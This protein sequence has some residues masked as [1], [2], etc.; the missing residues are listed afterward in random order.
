MLH[1]LGFDRAGRKS[2]L[3]AGVQNSA[4]VFDFMAA[5]LPSAFTY[6]RN[7]S[8]AT[9]RNANGNIEAVPANTP[10]FD[11]DESGA[12]LGLRI[13]PPSTNKCTNH[14]VNP[15]TTA[16]LSLSGDAAAVVSVVD[17][18]AGMLSDAGL[19][20]ICTNGKVFYLDN[21]AGSAIAFLDFDGEVGNVNPHSMR[22]YAASSGGYAGTFTLLGATDNMAFSST[23]MTEHL[24]ENITPNHPTRKMRI[25]VLAGKGVYFIL[26]QLEEMPFCTSPIITA[27]AAATR[28]REVCV[29]LNLDSAAWFSDTAGA[30]VGE[31]VFDHPT[32]FAEQY[33]VLATQGQGFSN[34]LGLFLTGTA[35]SQMRARDIANNV[36][37]H[38]EDIHRP[39]ANRRMPFAMSWNASESYAV[40]GPMR[41]NRVARTAQAAGITNLYVGGRPYGNAMS[42]WIRTLK[43][44][45]G[46]QTM[47][48]LGADMIPSM[49]VKAVISGGQSNKH[50]FFRAQSELLNSGEQEAIAQMDAYWTTTENWLI[51]GAQNTSAAIKQNDPN[52][53]NPTL[54][55]WWY[56]PVTGDFG[57][58][59]TYWESVA[60]AFGVDKIAAI[61]WDQGESDATSAAADLKA[62]WLAIFNRM[63][64][65]IG[66]KPVIITPIG[67][68]SDFQ[69][70]NYNTIRQAQQE[71]ASEQSWITLAPEK[72]IY[73]LADSVHLTDE[74]YGQHATPLMRR[75]L[76]TLG[77]TVTG[78]VDGPEILSVS[79]SAATVTVSL[80]HDGGTDFTPSSA[81]AGF[82]FFDDASEIA[83]TSAVRT[84]GA[85][86]T[87]TL[88]STPSGV[89]TLY[90][91]YGTLYDD[92]VTF[93]D[94]VRD[95]T[96]HALPLRASVHSL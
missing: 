16:G 42:G 36:N 94:L 78:G 13:E 71:L 57:G 14:N 24:L 27:G 5:T 47:S 28:Q 25:N 56:D 43:V 80:S 49:G 18:P 55:N 38:T 44:Y 15:T 20:D 66:D 70:A 59:M 48:A 9:R 52:A 96:T 83:I 86:I 33:A 30:L 81:I 40:A 4:Q 3:N 92:V 37:L 21:T 50:G 91:G 35:S 87:L 19:E 68:R 17:A 64:D 29:A 54:A 58:R 67:R 76:A 1:R 2:A 10:R 32:G 60:T 39:I 85:T 90:Y 45:N 51:N 22:L 73:P 79:R 46:F 12:P 23:E 84:N 63:R 6:T 69:G 88:A 89:E 93:T 26:S 95:N 82:K 61:D 62:A 31:A 75:I 74:G 72:F 11:Y 53:D 8:V 41:Y 7:D 34:A 65:V 77:E